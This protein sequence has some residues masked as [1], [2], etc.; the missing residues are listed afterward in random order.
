[1][2]ERVWATHR[3]AR[4]QVRTCE[5]VSAQKGVERGLAHATCSAASVTD[6]GE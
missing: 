6:D 1:M 4:V 2:Q 5:S 3:S